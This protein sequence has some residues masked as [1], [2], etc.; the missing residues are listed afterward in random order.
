MRRLVYLGGL[1]SGSDLSP[2]LRSR[3]EVGAILAASG[4]RARS[5]PVLVIGSG[6]LSFELVR[7][8]VERLPVM[9]TPRWVR[10]VTQPIDVLAYLVEA[11]DVPLERSAVVEIGGADRV[12]YEAL[13]RE[14]ARRRGLRRLMLPVPWLSPRPSSLW[15]GLVTPIYARVGRK[16]IEGLP[17][18]TVVRDDRA[19]TLFT[20]RPRGYREAIGRA[21]ANE[22]RELAETRWS[23][24]LSAGTAGRRLRYGGLAHGD[25]LVDVRTATVPVAP[26]RAFA[27]VR[28]IGGH[29]GWYHAD[30]LWRL[31]GFADI[32]AGG[33]GRRR[34]RRDR[35]RGGRLRPRLLARRGLRARPPAAPAG[36]DAVPGGPGSSSRWT[37]S[38]A[39]RG[40]ARP[41]SSTPTAW[42]G[43][44]TGTRC[45]PCTPTSLRGLLD[46]IA[47]AAMRG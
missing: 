47:R 8:L 41:P 32:L 24:A 3:Q 11:L 19:A 36:R 27:P 1:G 28:R 46:G 22:D 17:H 9:V 2:H 33:V 25:R 20:H 10:T 29:T 13:L 6:S 7:A 37:R 30:L 21:L 15:L 45:S 34:G 42:P 4:V 31:R 40:C 44:C 23:D 14:Y 18:E 39:A 38:R 35:R 16:L 12:P 26:A 5:G 43:G